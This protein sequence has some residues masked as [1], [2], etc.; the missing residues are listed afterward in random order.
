MYKVSQ[1]LRRHGKVGQ[2]HHTSKGTVLAKA[3]GVDCSGNVLS[4]CGYYKNRMLS[5][6]CS[7]L[8]SGLECLLGSMV[9]RKMVCQTAVRVGSAKESVAQPEG[10]AA[11][12]DLPERPVAA[13]PEP[14]VEYVEREKLDHGPLNQPC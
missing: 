7:T 11:V 6:V 5:V 13:I 2:L 3:C 8:G 10:Y 12:A 9:V 4:P 1:G 14:N